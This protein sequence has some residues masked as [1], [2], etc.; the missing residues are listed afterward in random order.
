MTNT[1][2]SALDKMTKSDIVGR[3]SDILPALA[4][5]VSPDLFRRSDFDENAAVY[6]TTAVR[7]TGKRMGAYLMQVTSATVWGLNYRD[8]IGEGKPY[9]DQNA[10][11][12]ALGIS[13]SYVSKGLRIGRAWA[14][15]GVEPGT[16]LWTR[17]TAYASLPK[18][19]RDKLGTSPAEG[20]DVEQTRAWMLQQIA[21]NDADLLAA[22][23]GE[24]AETESGETESGADTTEPAENGIG[25]D[26]DVAFKVL[27]GAVDVLG[28]SMDAESLSLLQS[29]VERLAEV[30][31]AATAAL[32]SRT[33]VPAKRGKKSA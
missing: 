32:D 19:V 26:V 27:T 17:V 6:V 2:K 28:K 25:H 29:M 30:G 12:A 1:T 18:S 3:V 5:D 24:S 21:E 7:E 22:A 14:E 8:M 11:A 31:A 13:K 15:Y 4:V 23:E 20:E 33:E 16:D 10:V 9:V